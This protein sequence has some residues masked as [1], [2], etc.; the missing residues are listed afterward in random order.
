MPQPAAVCA[1]TYQALRRRTCCP[2]AEGDLRLGKE[3][4]AQKLL[5]ELVAGITA[6]E[7]LRVPRWK[8]DASANYVIAGNSV[9]VLFANTP[10]APDQG[11]AIKDLQSALNR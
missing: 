5:F 7:A 8:A 1:S 4:F 9:V 10:P 3:K 6:D 2:R 11:K